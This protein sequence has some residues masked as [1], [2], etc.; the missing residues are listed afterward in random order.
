MH[1]GRALA[2]GALAAASLGCS[3]LN[4]P[5]YFNG[6][7]PLLEIQGTEMIPRVTNAATLKFRAPNEDEQASLD[8]Q[9]KALG[10]DVPW[11]SRDKVH[12][13][14]LFTVTNLD[15]KAG[16]FDVMVDGAT[17]YTKYDENIVAMALAQG[18]NDDPVYL[19]LIDLHPTLPKM[20]GPGE[21]YQGVFREDDFAEGEADL[22]AMGRWPPTGAGAM[23]AAQPFPAVLLNRS[24]VDPTGT[25]GVPANVV[26]PALVEVD[27]TLTAT[28][29]MQCE[30]TLRVR[31]D[32]DRLWHV[33]GDPHFRPMPTLFQPAADTP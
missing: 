13:E 11:V 30:W 21:V 28:A 10:F 7:S 31:D 9:K 33:D 6:P 8:A 32:D 1:L 4:T 18:N 22:D 24:E 29:H 17:Q 23:D 26:T 16:T 19:P 20:L 14:L 27:V 12:L 15:T 25:S 5:I 2:A 3:E